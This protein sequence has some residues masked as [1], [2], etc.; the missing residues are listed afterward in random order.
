MV[1]LLQKIILSLV[2][3]LQMSL[4][5]AAL[6]IEITQGVSGAMP[7]AIVPFGAEPGTRVPE[8]IAAVIA[9]DLRLSGRFS[10][11]PESDFISFP[12]EGKEVNFKDWR[13]LRAPNLV[14]GRVRSVAEDL[15]EIQFQLFDV[16][17][18]AQL[19]GM[20]LR[21]IPASRLRNAAHQISDIIY[22]RLTGE[23]GAFSTRV[24]FVVVE[25]SKEGDTYS[26]QVSDIDG[27]NAQKVLISKQPIMSPAWSPDGE[28]LAYVTYEKGRSEIYVQEIATGKRRVISSE[29]GINGAPAWS[30][31]GKRLAMTLSKGVNP[32][33]YVMDMASGQLTR[34]TDNYAID[35]EA[36]WAPDGASLVFTSDRGGKPQLYQYSFASK[37]VKR[38]TFEGEYNAR[39]SFSPNGR[40]LAMVNGQKGRYR[41]AVLELKTGVFQVLTDAKLDES[42][43]FAPNGSV[44]IYATEDRNRGILATVS[45]DGRVRQRLAVQEGDVREPAWAPFTKK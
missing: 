36:V 44:I 8:D 41:I 25:R 31:D 23:R 12:R 20:L 45:V 2:L 3:L 26:L 39:G 42:P 28:W 11:I 29:A 14:V 34:I 6:T 10:A 43:S 37:Q 21:N 35:T 7:I 30:P 40:Y 32:D 13:L 17:K 27:Y 9:S 22:E 33:I 4:L 19:E 15:Y 1:K 24:V 38:V 16:F 18:G 5:H